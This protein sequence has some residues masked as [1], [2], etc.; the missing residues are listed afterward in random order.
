MPRLPSTM[1][2]ILGVVGALLLVLLGS[3]ACD[4]R[5]GSSAAELKPAPG[6][7]SPR[8]SILWGAYM[9]GDTTYGA[10]HGNA[11]WDTQTWQAFE[12]HAGKKVSI[13]H[14]GVGRFWEASFDSQIRQHRKILAA[15]AIELLDV[16]SGEVPLRDVAA[17]AYDDAILAWATQAR[18]FGRAFF[19]RWDWEM[20]GSWFPW[21]TMPGK[22]TTAA[23][24]VSAWRHIHDLFAQ[25]RA[26]NVTWVWCPNA[27][28]RGSVPLAALYP[29]D[30]YV[31]WTCLDGYNKGGSESASFS[32]IFGPSY[33]ALLRIAP[34]KPIMIG[35]TASVEDDGRKAAWIADALASLPTRFPRVKAFA[36]FN[37]HISEDSTMWQWQ[38]ESS[39]EAQAAFA[40][41]IASP[42]FAP[43]GRVRPPRL[44]PIT[45]PR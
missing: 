2:V 33:R 25:A 13:V 34:T 41:A 35:E 39:P 31:D 9:E 37:W 26:T 10:P 29:G 22:D 19:L 30:R 14:W 28:F 18:A 38:I 44:A 1:R 23:E 20:N 42:Y 7:K 6:S 8:H 27:E 17:G 11:P 32:R 4:G 36:W 16:N 40:R 45:P 24:Y 15:G 5:P 43:G 21:G 12:A 3:A